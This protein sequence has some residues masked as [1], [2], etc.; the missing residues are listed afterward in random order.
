MRSLHISLVLA[1]ASLGF[2]CASSRDSSAPAQHDAFA[3]SPVVEAAAHHE[4]EREGVAD[5]PSA[6]AS[7]SAAP[8][9]NA[10]A[11]LATVQEPITAG[12]GKSAREADRA[13]ETRPVRAVS[14]ASDPI[15][16]AP[17]TTTDAQLPTSPSSR[18]TSDSKAAHDPSAPLCVPRGEEPPLYIPRDEVLIYEV[19]ID[20]GIASPT[21]GKVTMNARVEPYRTS[22][23]LLNHANAA[24][25]LE[26]GSMSARAE[27]RY[28]VYELDELITSAHLPQT[29]P[30]LIARMTQSGTEHRQNEMSMGVVDQKFVSVFREDG[31]CHVKNCAN[32]AHFVEGTWPWQSDHHCDGCKRAEHRIWDAPKTRP[33]PDQTLDML[34]AVYFSRTMIAEHRDSVHFELLNEED[35]WDVTLTRSKATKTVETPAGKFEAFEIKLSTKVPA[36]EKKRKASD[37]EGLFG[38]H[39][40]LSLWVEAKTG[41]PVQISGSVPIGPLDLGVDVQLKSFRG[42]PRGFAPRE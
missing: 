27:G 20:I 10:P 23:L 3:V 38:L 15:S 21:V 39:G 40:D 4:A 16:N 35:L 25:D 42:T 14:P 28:T 32:K 36:T 29:F 7:E 41:V 13:S 17:R 2:G 26:Q 11:P 12:D 6:A 1:V 34:S 24:T 5:Q 22:P 18:E 31:H 37:F 8:Q 30:S 9:P 19:S 33:A